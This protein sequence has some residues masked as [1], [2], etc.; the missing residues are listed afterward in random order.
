MVE[1]TASTRRS[2]WGIFLFL[3]ADALV[4]LVASARMDPASDWALY[5]LL[6]GFAT[7]AAAVAVGAL[8]FVTRVVKEDAAPASQR[9]RE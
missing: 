9:S 8:L 4:G 5:A 3:L 2:M 6:F 1:L 7:F